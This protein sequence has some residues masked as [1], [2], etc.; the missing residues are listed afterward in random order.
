MTGKTGG[1][2]GSDVPVWAE[3]D[4]TARAVVASRV[5]RAEWV[6]VM[7]KTNSHRCSH[8][9]EMG[10]S[11]SEEKQRPKV[12]GGLNGRRLESRACALLNPCLDGGSPSSSA[13]TL[14]DHM[15]MALALAPC[16]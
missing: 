8:C 11:L 2:I 10:G 3:A 13:G 5:A 9:V 7:A 14:T 1:E 6:V 16:V 4:P 15:Q 12:G